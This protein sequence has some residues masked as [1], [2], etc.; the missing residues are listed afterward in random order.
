MFHNVNIVIYLDD[1]VVAAAVVVR[2]EGGEA[3]V[4]R[5]EDAH[6]RGPGLLGLLGLGRRGRPVV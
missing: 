2:D 4:G 6:L 3:V 1:V 5:F